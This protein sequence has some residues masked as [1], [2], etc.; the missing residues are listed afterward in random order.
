LKRKTQELEKFKFVLDYKI[1]ELKRE[2]KPKSGQ[3]EE[4][5]E[6]V[7][8][9][10]QEVKHFTRVNKNLELI[11]DDLKMRQSGLKSQSDHLRR[12]MYAQKDLMDKFREET[13]HFIMTNLEDYKKLKDGVNHIYKTYSLE[14]KSEEVGSDD[15]MSKTTKS[16][17][18]DPKKKS[19]K[20]GSKSNDG[21]MFRVHFVN[22][23]H[24]EEALKQ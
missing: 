1:K 2:I 9:M 23:E 13:K 22:R 4:L 17:A 14:D 5:N 10:R 12:T 24:L 8:K 19:K 16:T 6:Q 21:D 18:K 20:G 7:T 11:V 15:D 3:I